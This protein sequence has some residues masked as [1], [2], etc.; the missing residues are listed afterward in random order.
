MLHEANLASAGAPRAGRAR[1]KRQLRPVSVLS[2]D[3]TL[4]DFRGIHVLLDPSHLSVAKLNEYALSKSEGMASE[5]G[6]P[7]H[8][9]PL[10]GHT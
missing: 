6:L 10:S 3:H 1:I 2:L 9:R 5:I 4:P 7:V 8:R